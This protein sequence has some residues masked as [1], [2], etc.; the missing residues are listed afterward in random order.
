[1]LFGKDFD[2]NPDAFA[3]SLLILSMGTDL[4]FY[5]A[6]KLK[7]NPHILLDESYRPLLDYARRTPQPLPKPAIFEKLD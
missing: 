6:A 1:M 5:F 7:R 3:K 4:R 2:A